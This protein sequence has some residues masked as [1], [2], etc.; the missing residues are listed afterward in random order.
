[1]NVD[2][3]AWLKSL[4]ACIDA[5]DSHGFVAHLTPDAE[6]QFGNLPPVRGTAGITTLVE[7]FFGSL[8]GL[9]HTLLGTWVSGDTLIC[10]GTV[11]YVHQDGREVTVPFAN[12]I[13]RD[14][15][16][17]NEYRIYADVSPLFA[18]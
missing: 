4:F 3:N 12:I 5:K 16:Q 17:A 14:G 10:R 8:R 7:G 1:M 6:F 2:E 18:R 9:Q 15:G 13:R 11:T